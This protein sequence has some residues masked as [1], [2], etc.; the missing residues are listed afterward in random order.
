MKKTK[1]KRPRPRL[2]QTEMQCDV[3][4]TSPVGP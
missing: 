1:K 4:L 3:F 2:P